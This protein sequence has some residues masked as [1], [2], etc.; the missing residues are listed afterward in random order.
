M[1]TILTSP[2]ASAWK[3]HPTAGNASLLALASGDSVVVA[4]GA[5]GTILRSTATQAAPAIVASPAN[6]T[7]AAGN[8]VLFTVTATGTAPLSYQWSV[9]GRPIT[10]ATSDALPLPTIT[11]SSAGGYAVT[12][13]NALGSTTSSV[14]TLTVIPAFPAPAPLFD[15]S[16]AAPAVASEPAALVTQPDGKMLIV[17]DTTR[18]YRLLADGSADSG[19]N[20]PTLFGTTPESSTPLPLY[21]ARVAL[22]PDGKIIYIGRDYPSGNRLSG[23]HGYLMRLRP[24][25]T[26]DPGFPNPSLIGSLYG[27]FEPRLLHVQSDGRI[28]FVAMGA[29][30]VFS[31][32]G[33]GI[34]DRVNADGTA[35]L[36]FSRHE[37][38]SGRYGGSMTAVV[39]ATGTVVVLSTDNIPPTWNVTRYS[40]DGVN[41]QTLAAPVDGMPLTHLGPIAALPDGRIVFTGSSPDDWLQASLQRLVARNVMTPVNPPVAFGEP[42]SPVTVPGGSPVTLSALIAGSAPFTT[43]WMGASAGPV[44]RGQDPAI[45]DGVRAADGSLTLPALRFTGTYNPTVANAAGRLAGPAQLVI[46]AP[47]APQLTRQPES[48]ATNSRRTAF[49][50]IES[51]GSGVMSYEWFRNGVSVSGGPVAERFAATLVIPEVTPADAGDYHVVVTNAL[52]T[53]TSATVTLSV[54]ATSRLANVSTRAFVGPGERTLIAGFSIAGPGT[55]SVVIRAVGPALGSFGVNEFLVDPFLTLHDS[56]GVRIAENDTWSSDS[57]SDPGFNTVGMFPL[58]NAGRDA[59]LTVRLPPGN[60]TAQVTAT[61]CGTGV[62]LAEVYENAIDAARLTNLSARA[63]VGTDAEIAIPGIVV[64]G[65]VPKSILVRAVGPTLAQFGITD[66]LA[67]PMLMLVDAAGMMI[68]TNNDWETNL[69]VAALRSVTVAVGAFALPSL[70]RDSALLVSV[71]PGSY[72][73]KVTGVNNTTGVALVEVYEVP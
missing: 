52:G 70:S 45:T 62:A 33:G 4:V 15:R 59:R 9:N 20:A 22:A 71:P 56:A 5:R 25:G 23:R 29:A 12:V 1:G 14:A 53:I 73:A 47:Q 35:D 8:N 49:F 43:T 66:P 17:D 72:T 65:M 69:N 16:F 18:V 58:V 28:L 32:R 54:D 46:V 21:W 67:N 40:P 27:G 44:D 36:S 30:G 61:D 10:G 11:A 3:T 13:A 41:T 55:K 68:A 63:F 48:L 6:L 37:Y 26:L 24:D 42:A 51:L 39:E 50:T 64:R 7:E 34:V 2:D 60:Y 19:F 38:S 57:G 31:P